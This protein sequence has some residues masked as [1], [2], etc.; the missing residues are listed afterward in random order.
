M[1]ATTSTML[2]DAALR[3]LHGPVGAAGGVVVIDGLPDGRLLTALLEEASTAYPTSD[4]QEV[5][6]DD[7]A[8]GRGGTPARRLYTAGGGPVQDAFYGAAWLSD[9][10]SSVCATRVRPTGTRGSYSYYVHVGDHLGLHLDIEACDVTLISVLRDDAGAE[11]PS[12]GLLVHAAHLGADL[13]AVR[14]APHD[15]LGL[16]KAVPGQ[17]VVLLGGLLPHET[18][19]VE[20]GGARLISA[21]CFAAG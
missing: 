2:P 4:R 21:L 13:H 18:V 3:L 1:T 6:V 8:P 11:E 9:Y 12:G 17:S 19:P 10:L 5:D 16:V 20:P 15:G 7:G 14:R